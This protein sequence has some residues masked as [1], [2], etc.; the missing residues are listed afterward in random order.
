MTINLTQS[1]IDAFTEMGITNIET[2]LKNIAC[3]HIEQKANEQ[4][5]QKTIEEK[6]QLLDS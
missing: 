6:Q 3:N 2:Y 1:E 4:L 5:I